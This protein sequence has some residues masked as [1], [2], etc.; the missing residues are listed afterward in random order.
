MVPAM[1]K[2]LS[3]LNDSVRMRVTLPSEVSV[4]LS[5]PVAILFSGGLDC[6][7]LALLADRHVPFAQPIE[8]LNVAFENVKSSSLK[9]E[10]KSNANCSDAIYNVPD[11]ITGRESLKEL[12]Y[13]F[14]YE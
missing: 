12:R 10:N 8:L 11:R 9:C 6:S 4:N 14:L 2:F 1:D 13:V 5:A 7:L 3:L